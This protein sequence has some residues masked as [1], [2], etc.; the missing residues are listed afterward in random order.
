MRHLFRPLVRAGLALALV[1]MLSGQVLAAPLYHW[2]SSGESLWSIS[3]AYGTTV[4]AI[5][6]ANGVWDD[7]LYP[8]QKL[9]IPTSGGSTS[10][11]RHTV[12]PGESLW[13]IARNYG[14][15]VE[16]IQ[17]AN[18]VW[19]STIYAGQTLVIPGA[20]GGS[21]PRSAP[22]S[23]TAPVSRG[24]RFSQEDVYLMAQLITAEAQGEPYE[25]QV[26]VGAVILNRV[27]S[28]LF[29]NTIPGVIYEQYQFEPVMNGAIY[30]QPTNSA[31]NAAREA[32]NGWDPSYG[33]LY[34]FNPSKTSNGFLWSRPFKTTIGNHR[35]TG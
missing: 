2:V 33:A 9:T 8:G 34:F 23:R 16:A 17:Q 7:Y 3:Q 14:T 24:T 35:F 25:G 19:D 30:N 29:P 22:A 12:A 5:R 6:Q 32:I 28:P 31:V 20:Q 10:G 4:D 15:T 21:A 13:T 18:G 27:K 26:A 1:L 11:S